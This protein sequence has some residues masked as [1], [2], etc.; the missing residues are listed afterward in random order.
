VQREDPLDALHRPVGDH[1]HRATG[2][3]LLGGLEDQPHPA[4]QA[5]RRGQREPGAEQ[6]RGVRVVP[7]GVHD[8][9]D[10]GR[11]R[12]AG[13]LLQRECVEV[14]PQGHAALAEADIADQPAAAR[15]GARLETGRH[16][17]GGDERGG[18]P[19]GATELRHRVQRSPPADE[20][21][22]VGSEPGVE[23]GRPAT[24]AEIRRRG[25]GQDVVVLVQH[26]HRA[27][28][29]AGP[30]EPD[31][32]LSCISPWCSPGRRCTNPNPASRGSTR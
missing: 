20:L 8:A 6:H 9:L 18:A 17:R 27:P 10:R 30:A 32:I 26:G 7:A 3:D 23:P 29:A 1:V 28:A 4:G 25:N 19:L 16:Q 14:G 24:H 13:V 21:A 2:L 5:G 31:A 11:E 15:Q 22:R 12:Q